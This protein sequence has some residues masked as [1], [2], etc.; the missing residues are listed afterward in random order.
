VIGEGETK[1]KI[2]QRRVT[3]KK[4]VQSESEEKKF[5]QSE[6]PSRAYKLYSPEGYLGSHFILRF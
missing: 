1:E 3:E 5:L 2:M 4:I 6:L